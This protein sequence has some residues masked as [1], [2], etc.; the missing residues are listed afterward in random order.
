MNNC[1]D[2]VTKYSC[3]RIRLQG[4]YSVFFGGIIDFLKV[5]CESFSSNLIYVLSKP[6]TFFSLYY[7]T[8]ESKSI[9]ST[10]AL[11]RFEM[12]FDSIYSP[13]VFPVKRTKRR[14]VNGCNRNTVEFDGK[15]VRMFRGKYK[16]FSS[17]KICTKITTTS[18]EKFALRTSSRFFW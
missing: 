3:I 7:Q 12:I 8:A 4:K 2:L 6:N 17:K 15:C 9:R 18:N 14:R 10:S 11:K 1:I 5:S 13:F 16:R